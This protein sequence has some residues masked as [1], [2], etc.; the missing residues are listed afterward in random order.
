MAIM[1]YGE[2]TSAEVER[3][4]A[5][6]VDA[7]YKVHRFLGPGLLESVYVECLIYELRRRGLKVLQQVQMPIVYDGVRLQSVL[8]VDILVEDVLIVEVKSVEQMHPIFKAQLGTYL[9]L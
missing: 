4:A 7:A 6:V 8:R 1:G 9:R 5:I 2:S 3:I